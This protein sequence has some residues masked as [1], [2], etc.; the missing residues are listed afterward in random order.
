MNSSGLSHLIV[1]FPESPPFMSAKYQN[2]RMY[3]DG[4]FGHILRA[5]AQFVPFS[6]ELIYDRKRTYGVRLPNGTFTGIMG[7]L[8]T[9]EADMAAAPL[10]VR[11]DRAEA[12]NF[13]PVIYTTYFSLLAVA[14]EPTVNAFS[15]IL[16][17]DWQ[18]W[19][20]LFVSIPIL[21]ALLAA[22]ET[23]RARNKRNILREIHDNFW[24]LL[25][26]ISYEGD[27]ALIQELTTND[28][29]CTDGLTTQALGSEMRCTAAGRTERRH[30][31]NTESQSF[32]PRVLPTTWPT[33]WPTEQPRSY[34]SA[35]RTSEKQSLRM[36]SRM[37][38]RHAGFVPLSEM[39]SPAAVAQ[40]YSGRAVYVNDRDSMLY[41][42]S[43][44][45][46]RTGSLYV[47][48]ELIFARFCAM[49]Y[50]RKLSH[51]V[52]RRIDEGVKAVIE[53]GLAA[54]WY[55]DGLVE[56]ERCRMMQEDNAGGEMSYKPLL[57]QDLSAVFI[58]W[59]LS[60]SFALM[61]FFLELLAFRLTSR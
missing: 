4:I 1:T 52:A 32:D 48:P 58:L 44:Q 20:I 35:V 37:A 17:F 38:Q 26:S 25:R 51:R 18:V 21:S 36:L 42:L 28:I 56:W 7:L 15:Y 59:A 22:L 39:N 47:A 19:A 40:L 61:A 41:L 45:C 6:Y 23:R 46:G 14:G 8:L 27:V 5:V 16:A 2:G 24:D 12:V 31:V 53:S 9:G 49:A 57:F 10:I 30:F 29:L 55:A 60:A 33:T 34:R 13:T 3:L 43:K 54:K 11:Q 50:S